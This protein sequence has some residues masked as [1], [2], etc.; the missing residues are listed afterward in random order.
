MISILLILD[1]L[2]VVKKA[3]DGSPEVA[4]LVQKAMELINGQKPLTSAEEAAIRERLDA[5]DAALQ[6]S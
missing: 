5:V 3:I 6:V 4:S 2:T 1:I